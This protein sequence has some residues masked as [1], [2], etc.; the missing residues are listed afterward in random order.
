MG[1]DP[2]PSPE[3]GNLVFFDHINLMVTDH[4]L[5]TLFYV[6]GLGLTRDPYRMVGVRN[7][8][9]NVGT[10][11]F[12]L[13]IG[14]PERF[15]GEIGVAFPDL[16]A[17][18]ARLKEVEPVLAGTAY[19]CQRD[20]GTLLV[21]DPWGRRYRMHRAGNLPGRNPLAIPYIEFY[22]APGTAGGIAAF[23]RDVVGAPAEVSDAGGEPTAHVFAGPHQ[24]L[25]FRE[26]RGE[27]PS[28]R[29]LH[30]AVYLSRFWEVFQR[31]ERMGI[32]YEGLRG[33]QF[34]FCDIP[35]PEGGGLLYSIEHEMRSLYH[36]DYRR[37]L[38]NRVAMPNEP[39][40]VAPV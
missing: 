31:M 10:Q 3:L 22:V 2:A 30:V 24:A 32:L 36:L 18:V 6:E 9:V 15:A 11:Q 13:P 20:N 35:A 21:H 33:E 19:R 37:P 25:R 28:G 5:A 38:V 7:M 34:R 14:V 39:G 29:A 8:W 23:Y 17:L 1:L 4:R 16:D 27:I 40:Y 26:K 12:H